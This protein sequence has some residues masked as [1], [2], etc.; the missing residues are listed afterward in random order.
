V[1]EAVSECSDKGM[2]LVDAAHWATEA[3]WLQLLARRL[4]TRF[5][6]GSLTVAVSDQVTDPWT[7]HRQSTSS[8]EG[9]S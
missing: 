8:N 9:Q 1:L 5:G 4:L 2:A 6:S 7:L 3:P